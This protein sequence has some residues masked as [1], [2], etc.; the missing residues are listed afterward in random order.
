MAL[1]L[2]NELQITK[3]K[4]K[5]KKKTV[6][7]NEESTS[8]RVMLSNDLPT[9]NRGSCDL[10]WRD[11]TETINELASGPAGYSKDGLHRSHIA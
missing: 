6:H 2:D 3:I 11:H 7:N 9:S 4:K 8:A 5:K 1:T 10:E